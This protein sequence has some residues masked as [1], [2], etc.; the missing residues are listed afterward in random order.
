MKTAR[1]FQAASLPVL[2]ADSPECVRTTLEVKRIGTLTDLGGRTQRLDL[3]LRTGC[4]WERTKQGKRRSR[5]ALLLRTHRLKGPLVIQERRTRGA[6]ARTSCC[7]LRTRKR[8]ICVHACGQHLYAGTNTD[9]VLF[10]H[11]DCS[12][13]LL[14]GL[15]CAA[16]AVPGLGTCIEAELLHGVDG[17]CDLNDV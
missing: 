12:R 16:L 10:A 3:P 1:G 15:G 9:S 14:G 13:V 11:T 7:L 6:H 17:L 5:T 4:L 2:A 8:H